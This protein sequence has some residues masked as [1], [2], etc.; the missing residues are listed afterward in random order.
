MQDCG[1]RTGYKYETCRKVATV[2]KA[3]HL[4]V[5]SE[6]N[7]RARFMQTAE[8]HGAADNAFDNR[9]GSSEMNGVTSFGGSLCWWACV[10]FAW[11]GGFSRECG[12]CVL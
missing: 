2:Q 1:S 5:E 4:K 6:A 9:S 12:P 7:A 8:T 11:R 10:C 3:I